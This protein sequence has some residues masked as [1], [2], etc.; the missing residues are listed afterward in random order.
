M[1]SRLLLCCRLNSICSVGIL[2][3][4]GSPLA[5]QG[6]INLIRLA[7]SASSHRLR[8]TTN[9][10]STRVLVSFLMLCLAQCRPIQSASR[11]L[12]WSL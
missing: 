2:Q 6:Y 4:V 9:E 10:D 8:T 5:N 1:F 12:H 11:E 3:A 7:R